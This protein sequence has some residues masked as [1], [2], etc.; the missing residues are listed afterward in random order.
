MAIT[1]LNSPRETLVTGKDNVVIVDILETLR[2]GRSLDVTDHPFD[3]IHSG[4]VIIKDSSGNYKPMPLVVA[5]AIVKTGALTAGSGYTNNGTYT[6]VALTGGSGSGA[7]ATVVVAGNKVTEVTITEPGSGYKVGDSLGAAAADIGED[8]T[9]F[10]IAVAEVDEA[11]TTYDSLP[12]S[13]SYV[14]V[15]IAT[16]NK[17]RPFAGILVRGTV[18]EEAAPYSMSTIKAAFNTATGD[19]IRWTSDQA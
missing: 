10:A 12:G 7:K 18:N 5:G 1:S 19:R 17:S 9:G 11:D 2:G 14:G 3:Y 6:D 15:L 8:G 13:H 4:H 16:I